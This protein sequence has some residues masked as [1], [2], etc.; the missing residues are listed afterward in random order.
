MKQLQEYIG[1]CQMQLAKSRINIS[2]IQNILV[3]ITERIRA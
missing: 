2:L 3:L 1:N